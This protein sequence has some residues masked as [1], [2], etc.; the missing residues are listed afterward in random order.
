MCPRGPVQEAA[1][2]AGFWGSGQGGR[3][4]PAGKEFALRAVPLDC[5]PGKHPSACHWFHPRSSLFGCGGGGLGQAGD[6]GDG[7]HSP[8][9]QQGQQPK[10]LIQY[11]VGWCL[12]RPAAGCSCFSGCGSGVG[13]LTSAG[14]THP[15]PEAPGWPDAPHWSAPQAGFSG[16][17][18]TRCFQ[19]GGMNEEL[20]PHPLLLTGFRTQNLPKHCVRVGAHPPGRG[21]CRYTKEERAEQGNACTRSTRGQHS[22]SA[23]RRAQSPIP[24]HCPRFNDNV[25]RLGDRHVLGPRGL[26]FS[27]CHLSMGNMS[28]TC[29]GSF[30]KTRGRASFKD[31]WS[32]G[33]DSE[34]VMKSVGGDGVV[35]AWLCP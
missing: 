2:T 35:G 30:S 6:P 27:L 21:G 28:G 5:G 26:R 15:L 18:T 23:G 22:T 10:L 4:V 9:G 24:Q 11:Q 3:V 34:G 25:H 29:I 20:W 7:D 32:W 13:R 14:S 1:A 19:S 8:L 33:V 17:L 16:R 12:R 31:I